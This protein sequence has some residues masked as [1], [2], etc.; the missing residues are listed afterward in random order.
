M[1]L[2]SR[3]QV[4]HFRGENQI[5]SGPQGFGLKPLLALTSACCKLG[6]F[7]PIK[8]TFKAEEL[9]VKVRPLGTWNRKASQPEKRVVVVSGI[10]RYPLTSVPKFIKI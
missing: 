4:Q 1:P 2:V 3:D 10:I 8:A 7:I 9:P 6:D 5:P